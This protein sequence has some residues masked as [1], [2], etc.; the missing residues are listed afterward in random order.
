MH[1]DPRF[2]SSLAVAERSLT[3]ISDGGGVKSYSSILIIEALM[4]EVI[5]CENRFERA[6]TH[7]PRTFKASEFRPCHYFHKMYGT[8]TG[9]LV[10]PLGCAVYTSLNFGLAVYSYQR[11]LTGRTSILA[12]ALSR[13]RMTVSETINM[14][15]SL[16]NEMYGHIRGRLPLATKYHHLPLKHA[17]NDVAKKHCKQHGL[18]LCSEGEKFRWRPPG[19]GSDG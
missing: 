12:I 16:L 5:A 9:G 13:L 4:T 14:F 19:Y 17:L 2:V 15:T 10:Q 8:S 1:T 3:R 7:Y 18:D 6:F 11:M